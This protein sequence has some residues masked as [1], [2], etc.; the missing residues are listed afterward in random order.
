MLR[1]EEL[2]FIMAISTMQPSPALLKELRTPL[3]SSK[4]KSKTVVSAGSRGT[5]FS[6]EPKASQ[7]PPSLSAGKVKPASR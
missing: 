2:G 4:K 5:M 7:H 6:G 1:Q 3:V